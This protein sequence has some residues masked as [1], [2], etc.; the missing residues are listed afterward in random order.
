MGCESPIPIKRLSCPA[1]LSFVDLDTDMDRLPLGSS[2]PPLRTGER[3][4]L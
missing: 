3:Q 4:S 2:A 1:P